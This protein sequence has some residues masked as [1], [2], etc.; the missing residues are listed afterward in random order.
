M[1]A[2]THIIL[3]VED[4][5]YCAT[6]LEIALRPLPGVDIRLAASAVEAIGLLESTEISIVV[7]DL[8]LPG[9]D[10]FQLISRIR[11][12]S[13][14]QALPIVVLSGD[15]NPKAREHALYLGASAFFAKPC[16]MT[17][18]RR[19]VEELLDFKATAT[20]V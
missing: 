17:L 19:T 15:T 13:R 10:G 2:V 8:R 12:D 6:T 7:T 20:C 1:R 14:L 4:E 16:S 5:D 3:I 9:M 18:L 11:S